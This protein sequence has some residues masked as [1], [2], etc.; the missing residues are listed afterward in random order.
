MP[1]DS[2]KPHSCKIQQR[3]PIP[4]KPTFRFFRRQLALVVVPFTAVTAGLTLQFASAADV[5]WDG[6][7]DA[8]G[9]DGVTFDSALNWSTNALPSLATP[10]TALFNGT[11][12]GALSLNYTGTMNGA[13]GNP[14]VNLGLA[15][16]QT[17]AVSL[18]SGAVV[19]ALRV[20]NINLAGG[21][22]ALTLGNGADTF[23]LTLGGTAGTIQTWTN[24][25][26]ATATV[27]SDVKFGLGGGGSHALHFSGSGDWQ[28]NAAV[29]PV[30][31]ANISIHKTGA[32]ELTLAGGGNL[33]SGV[34]AYGG[35][36]RA[37]L[38]EG[39]TRVTAGNIQ[40]NNGEFVVGGLDAG[41]GTSTQLIMDGGT[42]SAVNQLSVARGNGSGAVSSDVILNNT[43]SISGR[44]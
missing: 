37:V 26:L 1:G 9:G 24:N 10:D 27:N 34:V 11:V 19:T 38:Q 25:S 20:N 18:D 4:M 2:P 8:D 22:G 42:L 32:G 23:N 14:G 28:V 5:I 36:F 7:S 21:A 39:T 31:V 44:M 40:A 43:A 29:A 15:G 17:D 16:T 13:A 41:T 6:N 3:I 30:N 12:A 35:T 33:N